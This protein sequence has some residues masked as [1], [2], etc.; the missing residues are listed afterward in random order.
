MV[1]GIDTY[2]AK[3]RAELLAYNEVESVHELPLIHSYWAERFVLPLFADVGAASIDD[4]W[5]QHIAQQC[6][7]RAPQPARLVSLGAGN[8]E[9]DLPLV[10]RLAERGLRN[11][12]VIL[13]ELNPVMINRALDLAEHLGL[14]DR[15]HAKQA[16]L[17]TWIA[18]ESTDVYLAVH[19]LHHVVELEHL[20][21]EIA[22][23]ID[24]EGVL[25]VND[26]I[27]RNGHVRWP[28]AGAM[29]Q[30]I[31]RV[32]PERYRYNHYVAQ[33]D[34]TYPDVDCSEK[35]FEGVRSQD[36]LPLLLDR[37]HPEAYVTFGNVIDPFVDRAYGRNFDP[38]NPEDTSFIDSVARLDEAAI[39]LGIL[40]PT[41]LVAS[42]RPKPVRC[43]YPR[44]RSPDRTVR[45]PETAAATDEVAL[46]AQLR[47][48]LARYEALR[49]RKAVRTALAL[50]EL[51]HKGRWLGQRRLH[52]R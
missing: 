37:F 35:S 22:R 21:G 1:A 49:A 46:E 12:E 4:L 3:V 40:T 30:R 11:L 9:G 52:P 47:N 38:Q 17:N 27:G 31:W 10:A 50:A 44:E 14:R 42:F 15:V 18:D 36:V 28:E 51:R 5:E 29:V 6:I 43:R 48:T 26:M 8:G 32:A 20:Y 39:D 33:I 45:A 13:L 2:N 23:S 34:V 25:L 24:P 16:D 19:S 41:H 7:R